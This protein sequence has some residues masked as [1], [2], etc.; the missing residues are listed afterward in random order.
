MNCR[1]FSLRNP[2][3]FTI[4]PTA[5]IIVRKLPGIEFSGMVAV[6]ESRSKS[7]LLSLRSS[8][9]TV[10]VALELSLLSVFSSVAT[11]TSRNFLSL[12]FSKSSF[13]KYKITESLVA[14][15]W[16]FSQETN[17]LSFS[18]EV[19][20]LWRTQQALIVTGVYFH[21]VRTEP[22]V[23]A[24]LCKFRKHGGIKSQQ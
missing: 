14:D 16:S 20:E 6:Y 24:L 3:Y 8:T 15:N 1:V 23:W 17:W 5:T 7:G 2:K 22:M 4:Y 9:S 10:M 12:G 13:W 18:T 11:T 21:W 19:F